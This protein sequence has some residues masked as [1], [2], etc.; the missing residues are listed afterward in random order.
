VARPPA[1][2][3]PAL[4]WLGLASAAV[5]WIST[6]WIQV[7]LHQ[8]LALGRELVSAERLVR[9]KIVRTLAWTLHGLIELVM[10][11]RVSCID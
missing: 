6:G 5:C 7:P 11:G 9:S 1:G 4:P 2:V 3:G 10:I 8:W